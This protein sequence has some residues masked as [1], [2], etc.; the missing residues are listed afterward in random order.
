MIQVVC[1]RC[2]RQF[3]E[4]SYKTIAGD[5]HKHYLA[6]ATTL[7]R[8]DGFEVNI[9]WDWHADYCLDCALFL[10]GMRATGPKAPASR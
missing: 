7:A 6:L 10:S 2:K 1:D 4:A 9:S 3:S 5:R 8:E